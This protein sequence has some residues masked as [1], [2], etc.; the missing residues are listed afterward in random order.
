MSSHVLL[1]PLLRYRNRDH[2]HKRLLFLVK[3]ELL[4]LLPLLLVSLLLAL[5]MLLVLRRRARRLR[6]WREGS[7]LRLHPKRV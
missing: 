3:E 7:R 6:G 2:G 1:L 5:P 4:V